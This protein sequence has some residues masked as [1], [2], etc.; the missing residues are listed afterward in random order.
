MPYAFNVAVDRERHTALAATM[1]A[2]LE[3]LLT[4]S[5]FAPRLERD[6]VRVE[7][8]TLAVEKHAAG[9]DV[10]VVRHT[11][12]T[13]TSFTIAAPRAHVFGLVADPTRGHEWDPLDRGLETLERYDEHHSVVRTLSKPPFP[14]RMRECTL[15]TA[16]SPARAEGLSLAAA[17]AVTHPGAPQSAMP[18][19]LQQIYGWAV[20]DD[21]PARAHLTALVTVPENLL[22]LWLM[23]AASVRG[24]FA[25]AKKIRALLEAPARA[26]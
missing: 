17:R 14:F 9:S 16:A 12:L 3:G 21:G 1:L 11:L 19:L 4:A 25:L 20:R 24:W 7:T 8:K 6:G 22:P 10:P 15:F 5:D 26:V 23:K 2:E 13:R 18:R